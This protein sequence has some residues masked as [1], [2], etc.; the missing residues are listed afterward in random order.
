MK[1]PKALPLL[2]SLLAL[3]ATAAPRAEAG[4]SL[5]FFQESLAPHGEWVEVGG[6]GNCWRPTG[7]DSDWSPYS[8]GYW[9]YT[10]AGWTWVSY[11]DFG[12]IT[13]H[14]GRWVS[15]ED[16]GWCWTP[17]YEWGPAWVSWR[18]SDDHVGW[19]PLPPRRTSAAR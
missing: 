11:E 6:Y 3:L 12:S 13:Y 10:D 5:S 4:V 2:V 1:A 19:A 15:V 9:A 14:Y 18:H 7:V 16:E 17:G 8:D